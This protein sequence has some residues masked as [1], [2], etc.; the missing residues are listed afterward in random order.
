MVTA[1]TQTQCME[2][3]INYTVSNYSSIPHTAALL[4]T[5][6]YTHAIDKWAVPW[7]L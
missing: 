1:G 3:F 5:N 4:A 7:L 6:A 2:D